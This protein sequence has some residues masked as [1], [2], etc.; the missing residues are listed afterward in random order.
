MSAIILAG[1]RSRRMKEAKALLPVDG[2]PLIQV[3]ARRIEPYFGEIIISA[4]DHSRESLAFLPYRIV[5][6][7][8]PDRGPLMGILS[9]LEAARTPV[10]FVIACDIPEVD[11]E[12]LQRLMVHALDHEIVVPVSGENKYEPLFAFYHKDLAPRIQDLLDRGIGKIIELYSL[13]RVKYIRM[14]GRG[15][16]RNLNTR[17]DY[18]EYLKTR[19]PGRPRG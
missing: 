12:F 1:G 17:G 19:N 16:Y 9:G 18:R 10:N 3:I 4:G 5:L 15:W 7:K 8:E 11:T 6:D 14:E 2:I 13:A